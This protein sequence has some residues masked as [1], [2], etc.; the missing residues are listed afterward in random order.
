MKEN[1][2]AVCF[3]IGIS[4]ISLII[5]IFLIIFLKYNIV[6]WV[7]WLI[8]FS[9]AIFTGSIVSLLIAY[10]NYKILLKKNLE[11]LVFLVF[12]NYT[13]LY[14]ILYNSEKQVTIKQCNEI[15]KSYFEK[16]HEIYSII[17]E[18]EEV[19]S[20]NVK[21]IEDLKTFKDLFLDE[22]NFYGN[23]DKYLF[24]EDHFNK[25]TETIYLLLME[26]L[27]KSVLYKQ[28]KLIARNFG[29]HIYSLDDFYN[30]YHL[31]EDMGNKFKKLVDKKKKTDKSDKTIK[32]YCQ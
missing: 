1:Y 6:E 24:N 20:C 21:K 18:L 30:N 25:N 9:F 7:N 12:Q 2:K 5:N 27:E 3:L 17:H 29:V 16:A 31:I 4:I 32:W 11:R 10:I 22:Y 28:S 26:E 13:N 19:K 8:E 23:F 14:S 15:T